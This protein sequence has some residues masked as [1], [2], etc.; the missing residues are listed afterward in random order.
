MSFFLIVAVDWK[1]KQN[2]LGTTKSD[3]TKARITA[4]FLKLRITDGYLIFPSKHF[5]TQW[6]VR[7]TEQRQKYVT[8]YFE[9]YSALR[10]R[11]SW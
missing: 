6:L 7:T 11:V 5:W 10:E 9:V 3:L 4:Y 1:T 8:Y 2:P